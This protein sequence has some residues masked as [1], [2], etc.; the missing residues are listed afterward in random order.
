MT[1]CMPGH[2]CDP[3]IAGLAAPRPGPATR[4]CSARPVR[5]AAIL[6]ALSL[7]QACGIPAPKPAKAGL[8]PAIAALFCSKPDRRA[9]FPRNRPIPLS[10]E[11]PLSLWLFVDAADTAQASHT[12]VT[13]DLSI[14]DL[15]GQPSN[16]AVVQPHQLVSGSTR[17]LPPIVFF[18]TTPGDYR[19]RASFNAGAASADSPRIAVR[20]REEKR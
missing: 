13:V 17:R 6:L 10:T 18:A 4:P 2:R 16:G 15:Q 1:D 5:P 14:V 19:V 12:T 11:S 20:G 9:A 8:A 3:A 7:L